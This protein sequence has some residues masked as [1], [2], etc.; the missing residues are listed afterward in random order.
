MPQPYAKIE[1]G[2]A[3]R[4]GREAKG[5]IEDEYEEEEEGGGRER[6]RGILSIQGERKSKVLMELVGDR[7]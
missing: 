1:G 6:G 5:D 4:E 2:R 7:Y 3:E